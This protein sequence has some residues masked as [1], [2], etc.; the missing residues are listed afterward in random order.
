MTS[1]H[2]LGL[3]PGPGRSAAAAG[4]TRWWA[5][6]S[7]STGSR[8]ATDLNV[9]FVPWYRSRFWNRPPPAAATHAHARRASAAR[10]S[11]PAQAWTLRAWALKYATSRVARATAPA[12]TSPGPAAAPHAQS[13][14]WT[15]RASRAPYA[16]SFCHGPRRCGGKSGSFA[17][18]AWAA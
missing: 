18:A 14:R 2:G 6:R 3:R 11:A 5:S 12:A 16:L 15:V 9:P 10:G 17:S 1:Y 13:S 8:P 4:R 7:F